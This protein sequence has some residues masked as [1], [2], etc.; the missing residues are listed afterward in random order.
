[1]LEYSLILC[2]LINLRVTLTATSINTFLLPLL[3][4]WF[5]IYSLKGMKAILQN[6]L[7]HFQ[8]R[9]AVMLNS[10]F[11]MYGSLTRIFLRYGLKTVLKLL[12]NITG[13]TRLSGFLRLLE[14]ENKRN[15]VKLIENIQKN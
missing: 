3:T 4:R 9:N 7:T 2:L 6:T 13:F 1:M 11:L 15:S 8:R 5:Y 12:I 14:S 10:L